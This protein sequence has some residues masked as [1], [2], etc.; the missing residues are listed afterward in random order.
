MCKFINYFK[1]KSADAN[2]TSK[3]A[4]NKNNIPSEERRDVV[5]SVI[6]AG[7]ID[8]GIAGYIPGH[9]ISEL[10]DALEKISKYLDEDRNQ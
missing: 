10:D 2:L 5:I 3:R 6:V 4:F 9:L 1:K 7:G 8:N